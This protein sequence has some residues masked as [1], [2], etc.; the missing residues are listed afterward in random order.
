MM[1]L[2]RRYLA[3][4]PNMNDDPRATAIPTTMPQLYHVIV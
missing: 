3:P 2:F 4:Y 1:H